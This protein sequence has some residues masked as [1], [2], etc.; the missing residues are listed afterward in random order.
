M[1]PEKR[2]L[3]FLI[4]IVLLPSIIYSTFEIGNLN[5]YEKRIQTIYKN[6]LETVLF[7][8]NQFSE[9]ITSSWASQLTRDL[10]E[11]KFPDKSKLY[12]TL[13]EFIRRT[14]SIEGVLLYNSETKESLF[15]KNDSQSINDKEILKIIGENSSLFDK[16]S[17]YK[18]AGYRK[19]EVL[20]EIDNKYQL[21]TFSII[22]SLSDFDFAVFILNQNTFITS[23]LARKIE[24]IPAENFVV[25]IFN[26]SSDSLIFSTSTVRSDDFGI[27]KKLWLLPEYSTGINLMDKTIESLVRDR[28]WISYTTIILLNLVIISGIFFI[29]K[30]VSQTVKLAKL[31]TDFVSNVSHELRT[32]LALI[33]MFAETLELDRIKT[34]EKK[35]EY[36]RIISQETGRLS[37]IVN[38]ILNFAKTESGKRTYKFS[39]TEVNDFVQKIYDTYKFHL[40]NSGFNF[41]LELKENLPIIEID[42]EAISEA[43]INLID[44]AMK[45]SYERKKITLRTAANEEFVFIEVRDEGIGIKK[46]DLKRVFEKFVRIS[47]GEIHN[48]KG[49]G[50]GL[51]LVSQIIEA[52]NGKVEL[53]STYGKGS[54]FRLM[55]PVKK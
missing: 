1:S 4:L 52:H 25:S 10:S 29:F 6:Q 41:I 39:Q 32:P 11:S 21:I 42:Q 46:E 43:I 34:E 7:S 27:S 17:R 24:S 49:T 38:R 48:T 54:L 30:F 14:E 33:S 55:F 3:V 53:L 28:T 23:V 15:S 16:L 44:N 45:Y 9:D 50:L 40:S 18:D 26:T 31:K 20:G 47:D 2:L 19:L 8:I 13:N 22:N 5:D 35:K 51:S 12:T 37:N 36:Y